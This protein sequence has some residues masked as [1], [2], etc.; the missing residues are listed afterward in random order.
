MANENPQHTVDPIISAAAEEA[1]TRKTFFSFGYEGLTASVSAY[2]RL[3][4]IKKHFPEQ[5]TGFCVDPRHM[6]EPYYTPERMEWFLFLAEYRDQFDLFQGIGPCPESLCS[7]TE[8]APQHKLVDDRWL[9][10]SQSSKDFTL[11]VG[12][13]ASAGTIYQ[14]FEFFYTDGQT[15]DNKLPE[16]KVLAALSLQP[17]L[18]IRDLDFVDK[19]NKF[20]KASPLDAHDSRTNPEF[21]KVSA[22][23]N[24][25]DNTYE[26]QFSDTDSGHITRKHKMGDRDLVLHVHVLSKNR[27]VEFFQPDRLTVVDKHGESAEPDLE[28]SF[29]LRRR[30]GNGGSILEDDGQG[31]VLRFVLAYTM[32]QVSTPCTSQSCLPTWKTFCQADKLLRPCKDDTADLSD[33]YNLSPNPSLEFFLKKNLEYILSVCSVPI[34]GTDI[35]DIPAITLTCGDVEGHRVTT[36]AS[37]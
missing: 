22:T 18:L 8:A 31:R 2:G 20:N 19:N 37:L 7:H 26:T 13:V 6:P 33:E 1:K 24:L 15:K 5:R 10:F 29:G 9:T 27:S 34:P 32:K 14:K 35:D 3:L 23:E 12:Y 16:D 36:A 30:L 28:S 4:R 21:D 11:Q 17:D 25:D